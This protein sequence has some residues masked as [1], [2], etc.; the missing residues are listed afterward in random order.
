MW[1]SY[2][3]EIREEVLLGAGVFGEDEQLRC[4]LQECF[5][6]GDSLNGIVYWSES[7]RSF[8]LEQ[9]G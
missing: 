2:L 1:K 9:D 4:L 7:P 5:D 3:D 6:D 8:P